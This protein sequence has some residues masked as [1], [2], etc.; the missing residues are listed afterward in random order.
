MNMLGQYYYVPKTMTQFLVT[1]NMILDKKVSRTH[2][3]GKM[4]SRYRN[5]ILFCENVI[6]R[7]TSFMIVVLTFDIY[8]LLCFD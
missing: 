2:I 6:C 1:K 4:V 3:L 7:C 8:C 5:V